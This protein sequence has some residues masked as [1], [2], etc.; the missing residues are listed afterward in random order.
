MQ[1]V[2]EIPDE[3][4]NSKEFCNYFGAWSEKLD[5]VIKHAH[6]LP[7]GHGRLVDVN[8]L[9]LT[10]LFL[11]C[12]TVCCDAPTVVPADKPKITP[13]SCLTNQERYEELMERY[14]E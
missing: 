9:D 12:G 4:M 14:K 11:V 6:V 2:I 10:S 1:I 13:P 8:D 5:E 7:K 3:V